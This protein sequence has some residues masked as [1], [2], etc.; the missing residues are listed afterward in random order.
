MP[1]GLSNHWVFGVRH[2]PLHPPGDVVI[3]VNTQCRRLLIDLT[4]L[5]VPAQILSLSSFSEQAK[6]LIPRLLGAFNSGSRQLARD[7]P[8]AAPWTWATEDPQLAKAVEGSFKQIGITDELCRVGECSQEEKDILDNVWGTARWSSN[9]TGSW[10]RPP[11]P[12]PAVTPG[13]A[14]RCHGCGLGATSFSEGLKTCSGC[15][16]A[17]YHSQDCQRQNWKLHMPTC[18]AN[19]PTKTGSP[20]SSNIPA[21][22]ILDAF[23]YYNTIA[24]TTADAQALMRTIRLDITSS[25]ATAGTTT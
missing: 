19:R 5:A 14:S 7:A 22:S 1:G 24:L 11:Q 18:L 16:K 20:S 23:T 10:G 9:F 2:I 3:A 21:S 6:V 13:D 12:Q 15:R 8:R 4:D 17:F 25:R